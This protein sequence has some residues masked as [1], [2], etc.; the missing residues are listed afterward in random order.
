MAYGYYSRISSTFASALNPSTVSSPRIMEDILL[1][2]LVFKILV[3]MATWLWSKSGKMG[4]KTQAWVN[5]RSPKI[6]PLSSPIHQLEEL[7]QNSVVQLKTL[8]ELRINLIAALRSSGTDVAAS[9]TIDILTRHV[10]LFGKFFRR[11]Q[12]L[13]VSRFV[14]LPMCRDLVLYYWDKVV[15][16]TNGPP[17][18]ISGKILTEIGR[19]SSDGS[20]RHKRRSISCPLSRP[21]PCAVQGKSRTMDTLTQ[22]WFTQRT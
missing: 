18:L 12:Q 1:G 21:R 6:L 2:H 7:F 16:A 9:T 3:K 17:E 15:Q 22:R 8:I 14:M 10:R 5:V 11:L 19:V 13:A 20:V 4:D